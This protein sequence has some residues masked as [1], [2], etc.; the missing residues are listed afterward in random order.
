MKKVL[1][2]V[3]AFCGCLLVPFQGSAAAPADV[4]CSQD[5]NFFT[6]TARNLVVPEFGFCEVNAATITHDLIVQMGAGTDVSE[7][8]IGHDLVLRPDEAGADV[9]DTWIGHDLTVGSA[10]GV[11]LERTSIGHDLEASEPQTVQTGRNGPDSSGGPVNIGH[12]LLIDG[13][14]EGFAFVFDGMCALNVGHDMKVTDR[15]VTLGFGIGDNC[16]AHG[17]AENVIGNDL[18][19][20]GNSALVGFFGPSSLEVGNNHVGR[21]LVFRGNIAA[22]GGYLEVADNIVGR[23]AICESNNPVAGKDAS[24]GPNVAGRLNTCG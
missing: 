14:P 15:A 17:L 11:H 18:I 13:S 19:V 20:I 4:I 21:D 8:S 2:L 10:G 9:S 12:D 24:D 22:P 3:A 6:G 5:T 16:A 7:S 23:D 1:V